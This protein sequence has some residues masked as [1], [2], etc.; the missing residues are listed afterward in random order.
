MLR[1]AFPT[2]WCLSPSWGVA[3]PD[4]LGGCAGH[5][6]AVWKPGYF[7]LPLAAAEA[8]ALRSL[9]VVPVRGP[10]MGLSLA[11]P[12]GVGIGLRALRRFGVCGPG[13]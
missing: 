2:L 7:C 12:S 4:L 8:A 1:L 5:V 9:R 6:E 13:H 3:S 11:G 10:A